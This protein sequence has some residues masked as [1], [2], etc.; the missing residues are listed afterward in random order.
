MREIVIFDIEASCEDRDIN[1]H[2]N[3]E[4][5][6]I[7]AVK[8]NQGKVI[9][10]F[11]ILIEPEY[12][13]DLT[14]F[15]VELTGITYD[16]LRGQKKFNEA[17][18]DFYNF[19]YGCEIYSCGEFDRKFLIRELDEKCSSYK[20]TL[21]KNAINSSHT[22]L[23]KYYSHITG[24]KKKGM[25]GMAEELNIELTGSHHRALSDARNLTNIYFAIEDIRE[26]ELKKVFTDD[27]MN[28]I[29]SNI[30][31]HHQNKYEIRRTEGTYEGHC[32]HTGEV[33]NMGFLEFI[34]LWGPTLIVDSVYRDINYINEG[35]LKALK[36]YINS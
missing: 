2:Y 20:H 7:G 21:I 3:M 10:T 22:D 26:A 24:K 16:D 4:T 35:Q 17:I 28:V 6:E 1:P 29:V 34:D 36:K 30:N 33:R 19:I 12:I 27:I 8:V 15:C 11:E 9:D 14:R 5:I 13:N 23:K 32:K 25:I 31:K 18:I